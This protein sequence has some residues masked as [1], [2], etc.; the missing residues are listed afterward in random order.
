[1]D[2]R[3]GGDAELKQVALSTFQ[4]STPPLLQKLRQMLASGN[5]QGFGLLAH[6]AKG[7]GLMVS[8]DRYAAIAA[9][10]E[11]RAQRAPQN[12]LEKLLDELQ[13]AF[14]EFVELLKIRAM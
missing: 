10:L 6:S 8:A 14:E 13:R 12:E 2:S 3:F 9:M 7:G 11:D 4:Q 5:R 1:M